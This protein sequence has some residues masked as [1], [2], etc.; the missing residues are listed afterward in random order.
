[1][2][3]DSGL[4]G[5]ATGLLAVIPTAILCFRGVSGNDIYGY[6]GSVAVFGFLT[7]YGLIAAALP[8]HMH[9]RGHLTAPWIALSILSIAAVL[10]AMAGTIFPIPPAPYRYFPYLYL[11]YLVAGL[12]WYNFKA[13]QREA[14]AKP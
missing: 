10:A 3:D 9:R 5:L 8:V 4:A 2:I 13:G 7:A 14:Q 1:M 12:I 11:A 6:M